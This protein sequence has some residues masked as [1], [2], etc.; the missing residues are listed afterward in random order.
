MGCWGYGIMESD[1]ALDIASEFHGMAGVDFEDGGESD[2]YSSSMRLLLE[3]SMA[4]LLSRARAEPVYEDHTIFR[5]EAFQVLAAIAMRA[6]CALTEEQRGELLAGLQDCSE[7]QLAKKIQSEAQA[8]GR[9][10]QA[11]DLICHGWEATTF[12]FDGEIERLYGRI[13]A[14]EGEASLLADYDIGGGKPVEI[15]T[16]GL[17]DV[18]AEKQAEAAHKRVKLNAE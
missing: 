4:K 9:R 10:I 12:G 2:E 8:A 3:Q 17:F 5:A 15:P 6:G 16:R 13:L 7:F 14:V 11:E 1:G 18:F